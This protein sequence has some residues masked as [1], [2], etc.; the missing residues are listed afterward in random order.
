MFQTH[1]LSSYDPFKVG[2]EMISLPPLI[3]IFFSV[4]IMNISTKAQLKEDMNSIA[5]ELANLANL[6]IKDLLWN[7]QNPLVPSDVPFGSSLIEGSFENENTIDRKFRINITEDSTSN[8]I[9]LKYNDVSTD[10][11]FKVIK[12][13]DIDLK[14]VDFRQCYKNI[15]NLS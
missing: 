4:E 3:S 14:K 1:I 5:S 10:E 2:C 15:L 9:R 8:E 6:N 13:R 7:G 12:E 11:V